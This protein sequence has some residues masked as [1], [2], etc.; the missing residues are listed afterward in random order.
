[1][2]GMLRKEFAR[3]ALVG[4]VA[5]AADFA[6][7]VGLTVGL[8][9]HYLAATVFAFLLGTR[10][11]YWL[12]VRWVFT[13]RAL[14][15]RSAEFAVFL[16]VG[17]VT[18]GLSLALMAAL[19]GGLGLPVLWAKCIT[20]AFTLGANFAGRRILLFSRWGRASLRH[21]PVALNQ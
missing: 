14:D 6:V 21:G 1:M 18:L 20:A 10:V 16:L 11:N 8:G 15:V 9:I 2:A 13:Y 19:V 3:Y 7:L 4:G 12:S 5:F 17:V